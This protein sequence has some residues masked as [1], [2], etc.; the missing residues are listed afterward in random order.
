MR[1]LEDIAASEETCVY[2][3]I[4]ADELPSSY[5]YR[6]EHLAVFMDL[7]PVA[8]GHMLIVPIPHAASLTEVDGEVSSLMIVPLKELFKGQSLFK[9]K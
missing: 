3:Q 1:L 9:I 8:P 6:D 2:C 7:Y 5:E 4:L